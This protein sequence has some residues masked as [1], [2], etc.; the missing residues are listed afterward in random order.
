M[1]AHAFLLPFSKRGSERR[2]KFRRCCFLVVSVVL[3]SSLCAL[4]AVAAGALLPAEYTEEGEIHEELSRFSF[5]A[6]G[7]ALIH[8]GVYEA[9]RKG[10]K[11]FDFRP[12][13]RLV[14]ERIQVH[15]V[16]FYNQETILGGV[17]L[18]LSTYPC[19]N[20]P[21]EVG[22]GMIDTGFN[23]V[24]LANNHTLDRGEKAI[25]ASHEYW[26]GRDGV[27]T[28]GSY[29]SQEDRE[30]PR[31]VEVNGITCAFLAY[32]TLT[33][34]LKAPKDKEFY[35]ALYDK[36]AVEA[37][38]K[39]AREAK[40]DVVIVSMH[41]GS[42]YVF[43]PGAQQKEIAGH[44]A[45]LG[46]NLVVGHHPHVVQPV[47]MVK[48][49]LVIYSLGNFISSQKELFKLIGLMVS[50]DVV[51]KER[52]KE[53]TISFENVTGTLLYNPRRSPLGRYVV[54]PFD[55]MKPD[56]L[57]TFDKVYKKYAAYVKVD[58][59]ISIRPPA[60]MSPKPPAKR[61]KK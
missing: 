20:S 36:D 22:E 28:A 24:S 11:Q 33:N 2:N 39:R 5:V 4:Q 9:A 57:K 30:T 53:K 21:Q 18:R 15:D 12:M 46:V 1:N 48:D 27:L 14:K 40:A 49:T 58:E 7:D 26:A 59:T 17:D 42:E 61:R 31:I 55:L 6:V 25:L 3:L 16:A 52:G 35:V 50:L 8:K 47:Q 44:L 54:V 10:K 38:V 60:K 13:F 37:D 41:W 43:T 34:G 45:S 32:T 51:K 19:F 23:F 56:I 29:A